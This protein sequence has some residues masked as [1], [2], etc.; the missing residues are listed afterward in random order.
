M[1]ARTSLTASAVID[2]LCEGL[3]QLREVLVDHVNTRPV[4]ANS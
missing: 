4:G 2:V 1:P 3:S